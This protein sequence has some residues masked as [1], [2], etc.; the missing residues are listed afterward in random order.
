MRLRARARASSTE[1]STYSCTA[2]SFAQPPAMATS[3]PQSLI[4]RLSPAWLDQAQYL[5]LRAESDHWQPPASGNLRVR[6]DD[7]PPLNA[8]LHVSQSDIRPFLRDQLQLLSD[9]IDAAL[10]SEIDDRM[11]PVHPQVARRRIKAALR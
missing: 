11:P 2:S 9:D 1:A 3:D 10:E 7:D 4:A 8:D 6:R 5:L